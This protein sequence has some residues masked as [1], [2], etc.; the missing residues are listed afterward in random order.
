MDESIDCPV[1][2]GPDAS[3]FGVFVNAFR[4]QPESNHECYLDFCVYSAQENMAEV[5][6]RLRVHIS[7]LAIIRGRLDSELKNLTGGTRKPTPEETKAEGL[8]V[9]DGVLKTPDGRIV[10]FTK[11]D[12]DA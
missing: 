5:V 10:F 2:F 4:V 1:T 7:F 11:A 9:E 8:V 6:V 3:K 12:G